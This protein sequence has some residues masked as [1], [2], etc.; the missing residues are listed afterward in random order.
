LGD[1][2]SI[3]QIFWSTD[4]MT[5][6]AIQMVLGL[7]LLSA[8]TIFIPL[9][10]RLIRLFMFERR[11]RAWVNDAASLPTTRSKGNPRYPEHHLDHDEIRGLF[12]NSPIAASYEEFERR[13]TTAL[14]VEGNEGIDRAPIRL[15]DVFDER[16]LL[17]FGPRRS[18]LPV[19]PGLFLGVGVF[20]ALTGLIPSLESVA[21]DALSGDARSALM[22]TQLGLAL[23][24]SAWGFICAIGATLTGR[25]IQG[26]YDAR[27]HGLDEIVE[28]AFGSVSPGELAEITR[29]TQQKSLN[30]LGKELAGF[31][32]ELSERLDRGLQRSTRSCG[33]CRYPCARASNTT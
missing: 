8:V 29:Q 17:P 11:L 1:P 2:Y 12:D 27:S 25:L 4:P 20:A 18:L 24:A 14:L 15:M 23:R 3:T 21:T 6:R 26:A 7:A 16:P 31:A 13:W 30:T 19:M 9:T 5:Q 22:A 28:N 33:S 32:K 10:M